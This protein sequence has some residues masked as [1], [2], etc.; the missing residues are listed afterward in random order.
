MWIGIITIGS[1]LA[2]MLSEFI[3]TYAFVMERSYFKLKSYFH[4][5]TT[6]DMCGHILI[7]L[8]EHKVIMFLQT[9]AFGASVLGSYSFICSFTMVLVLENKSIDFGSIMKDLVNIY[10]R[11][12]AEVLP[13]IKL[14]VSEDC[15]VI[16]I[17]DS[18]C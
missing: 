12:L 18:T 1:T 17:E 14:S 9:C 6:K 4:I 8:V 10:K 7:K 5:I 15:W 2:G 3:N 11:G 16:C 13:V